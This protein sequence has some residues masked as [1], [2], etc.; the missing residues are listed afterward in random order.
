MGQINKTDK[1]FKI[2]INKRFT[3]DADSQSG[4]QYYQE[5]GADT[6]NLHAREVWTNP[7][8]TDP[9]EAV[10]N[11]IAKKYKQ[12]NTYYEIKNTNVF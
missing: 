2:L 5:D 7:V 1:N 10:L 4:R 12:G 3:T 9:D 8:P 11:N 6:L